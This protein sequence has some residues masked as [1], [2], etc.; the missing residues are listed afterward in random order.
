MRRIGQVFRKIATF[1][2]LLLCCPEMKNISLS[3]NQNSE[4]NA[5]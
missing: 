3:E 5:N 4:Q 1:F 2:T